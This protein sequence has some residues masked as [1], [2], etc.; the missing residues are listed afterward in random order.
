[1]TSK[2]II[3]DYDTSMKSCNKVRGIK[4]IQIKRIKTI[5]IQIK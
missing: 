3:L 1:M 5:E 4:G 2:K